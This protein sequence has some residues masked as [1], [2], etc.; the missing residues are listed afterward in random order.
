MS[1][2]TTAARIKEWLEKGVQKGATHC[3]I[4][5]DTWDM[6]NGYEDYPMYIMPGENVREIADRYSNPQGIER[7]V[8]VYN[9]A[10]DL[11]EQLKEVRAWHF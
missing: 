1:E 2:P 5:C 8:E 3:L 10:L 6:A 9:L 11:E 4:I 7:L